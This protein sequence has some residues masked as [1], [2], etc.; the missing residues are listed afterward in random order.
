MGLPK[1]LPGATGNGGGSGTS[2]AAYLEATESIRAAARWLLAA[3]AGVGGVL[4][5]GVPLTDIG[6]AGIWSFRF[7]VGVVAIAVALG[8]IAW[9]IRAVAGVFTAEYVSFGELR[10]AN[11]PDRV[12]RTKAQ[13]PEGAGPGEA[14]PTEDARTRR[15]RRVRAVGKVIDTSREELYGS[16]A[17]SLAEL[18][19]HLRQVNEAL[20]ESAGS[21]SETADGDPAALAQRH[22]ALDGA[23]ARVVA[24]ANYEY[25]RRTFKSLFPRL[26]LLGSI[27][28]ASV[29]AYA[30]AISSAPPK[31]SAVDKPIPVEL[32]SR[33]ARLGRRSRAGVQFRS[34]A[35]RRG[36][37][38]AE[39]A[40]GRDRRD[41]N[42]SRSAL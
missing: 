21:S 39:C 42:L 20:A 8:S 15:Q 23:A 2:T 24:F 13:A 17:R 6:Q 16:H 14:K 9:M 32:A 10:Q 33:R 12:E 26:A 3:F 7:W 4:V 11:F 36:R 28:A 40:G 19:R 18:S 1:A 38:F 27:A 41:R 31:P 29:V 30:I 25:T 34:G 5:A 22:A 35:S 37:R